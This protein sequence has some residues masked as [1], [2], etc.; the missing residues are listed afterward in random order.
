MNK[1]V[2][3]LCYIDS[4][5]KQKFKMSCIIRGSSMRDAVTE[6]IREYVADTEREIKN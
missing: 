1:D 5:L 3:F 2:G 4:D 6:M